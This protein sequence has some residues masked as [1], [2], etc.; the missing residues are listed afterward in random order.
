MN[1]SIGLRPWMLVV[2]I[3]VIFIGIPVLR[4]VI[5]QQEAAALRPGVLVEVTPVRTE[6]FEY[7]LRYPGTIT[8]QSTTVVTP[9]IAG[10][11]KRVHVTSGA[12]VSA[13]DVMVSIDDSMARLQAE[14][15]QAGVRAAQ[16]QLDQARRGVRAQ[17]LESA[18][19]SVEQAEEEL[20]TARSNLER[21]E[22]LFE[23]GTISRSQYEDAENAFQSARTQV[24]NARRSLRIMEE[25]ASAEELELAEA[26]LDSARKQLELAELQLRYAEVRAPISGRIAD[27]MAEEGNMANTSTALAAIIS[28]EMIQVQA[29]LPEEYYGQLAYRVG[30]LQARIFPIAYPDNPPYSG[31]LSSVASVIQ[32]ESRT[33]GIEIAVENPQGRLRPGMFVNLELI[34]R[35]VEDALVLPSDALLRRE[36][37]SVVYTIDESGDELTARMIPVKTGGRRSGRVHITDGLQPDMPVIVGGNTFLEDGQLVR[38]TG[39]SQ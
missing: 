39:G 4:F 33:F 17:E 32:P 20:R 23:A 22:R 18:R 29:A 31:V 36:G 7:I 28:D 35:S 9:R 10:E 30:D 34:L 2:V 21:T 3:I 26:N 25:G 6:T 12:M 8:P 1:S 37:R 15:A 38:R 13:G 19:A 5:P 14:Q 11:I 24:E 27:V 16:A